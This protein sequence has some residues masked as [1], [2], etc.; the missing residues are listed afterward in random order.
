RGQSQTRVTWRTRP[1]SCAA[2]GWSIL[3]APVRGSIPAHRELRKSWWPPEKCLCYRETEDLQ[4]TCCLLNQSFG[5]P[6]FSFSRLVPSSDGWSTC[7]YALLTDFRRPSVQRRPSS[8]RRSAMHPRQ[9]KTAVEHFWRRG[10]VPTVETTQT[11]ENSASREHRLHGF[12]MAASARD[13][14]DPRD[15]RN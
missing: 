11:T 9:N 2:L 7:V 14:N 4:T 5:A 12:S 6:R 1:T 10:L 15:G 8:A 3:R 13:P